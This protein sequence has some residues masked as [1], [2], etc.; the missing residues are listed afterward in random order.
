MGGGVSPFHFADE[1]EDSKPNDGPRLPT[2]S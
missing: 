1:V 2:V